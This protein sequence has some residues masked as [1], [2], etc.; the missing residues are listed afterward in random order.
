MIVCPNC[1]HQ[2]PNEAVHCE[3]CYTPL[4]NMTH[5]P[6]C[7]ATVQSDA[8]FCGQCGFNLQSAAHGEHHP[9]PH[10]QA[11]LPPTVAMDLSAP[12]T[13]ASPGVVPLPP[14][15]AVP[16]T[17]SSPPSSPTIA[18]HETVQLPPIG[19]SPEL[20][21][22]MPSRDIDIPD[23]PPPDP[24]VQPELFSAE[25]QHA[26]L[27]VPPSMPPSMP[28]MYEEPD[29]LM[30]EPMPHSMQSSMEADFMEA[31]FSE[32]VSSSPMGMNTNPPQ[33]PI[34][35]SS[36]PIPSMP[37]PPPPPLSPPT[38][39]QVPARAAASHTI[40]QTQTARLLHVQTN[41]P[42]EI[43]SNLSVIHIGKPNDR[44]PPDVDVSGFP[45]S[46]IVSRVHADIRVEG[47]L[48]YIEDVG[49]ANGTYINN[50]PLPIGNR[51]RLRP[52]DRIAL[53]KG[54]KVTFLFQIS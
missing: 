46:E 53:G 14:T 4:P 41:T 51:H 34:P 40:L 49:S 2:N 19:E 47:D 26:P 50:L 6:N 37:T 1:T 44:V 8:S 20:D 18:T 15:V 9:H 35:P 54:D 5:C 33:N 31:D 17:P 43:P 42:V 3:A 10:Q 39:A 32:P 24:I 30:S 28:P 21:M 29:E 11:P 22:G 48:Y 25:M 52:G 27:S 12:P 23:L 13:Q 38:V 16:S 36:S 7:H 45:N